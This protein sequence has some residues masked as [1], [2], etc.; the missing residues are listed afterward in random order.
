M[1]LRPSFSLSVPVVSSSFSSTLLNRLLVL[2]P[3]DSVVVKTVK[4]RYAK[5]LTEIEQ[6]RSDVQSLKRKMSSKLFQDAIRL[7]VMS[8]T[9]NLRVVRDLRSGL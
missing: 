3:S 6:L 9:V 2:L 1:S 5:A 7:C 8:P 4:E